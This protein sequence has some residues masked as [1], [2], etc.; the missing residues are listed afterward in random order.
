MVRSAILRNRTDGALV[1]VVSPVYGS[2]RETSDRLV[3]YVQ[4]LYPALGDYLPS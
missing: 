4:V 1:R 3:G 2:V